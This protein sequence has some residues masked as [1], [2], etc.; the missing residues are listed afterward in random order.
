MRK[1]DNETRSE[2]GEIENLK[3]LHKEGRLLPYL[4]EAFNVAVETFQP[5]EAKRV[6]G[7][8]TGIEV[9]KIASR[10]LREPESITMEEVRKLAASCLLDLLG[11]Q[12]SAKR[13]TSHSPR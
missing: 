11:Y 13:R 2:P 3:R 5:T 10:A 12:G 9:A 4:E 7:E 8:T 6:L 1:K